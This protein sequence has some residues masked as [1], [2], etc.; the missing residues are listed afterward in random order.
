MSSTR[1]FL[2][3]FILFILLTL[4]ITVPAHAFDGRGGD[5]L[6]IQADQV[7]NDD[8]YVGANEFTLNGTVNGD[9]YVGAQ[10]VTINGTINGNLLAGAQS[11]IVNGTVTGDVLAAGSVLYLGEKARVGGDVLGAAYSLESRKGAQVGRDLVYAGGQIKLAG[12]V[13]RDVSA[14]TGAMEID[15]T[16]GGNVKA[17]V[18][19]A[20]QT[21]AG[22]PPTMFMQQTT[23]AV[24]Q[25]D[26]GLTIDPDAKI[27][28]NLNYTQNKKL[29]FPEGVIAG[30][31]TRAQ[32]P[33]N[34]AKPA[35]EETAGAKVVKW[36]FNTLR[37]LVTIIL[38][39]L[40]L[41]WLL[42]VFMNSLSGNLQNKPWPS[43]GWGLVTYAGFFFALLLIIF[44][45]ILGGVVFGLLTLGG[46]S[47]TI[48]GL[49]ILSLLGLILGFVLVVSF[50][51][52]IVFGMALGRWILQK[53]D[54]PLA[55]HRYWP[56][57][58]GVAITV[59]VVAVLS[60]PLLPGFLGWLLNLLIVLF[61]L[62]ALWLWGRQALSKKP[63]GA[64]S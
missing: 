4:T 13:T 36:S 64:A 11:V 28:G 12:D 50:L 23:V 16:V 54:S 20:D 43:L 41:L 42:P 10:T 27:S 3:I 8:L 39:G 37:S 57:V 2:S 45:T 33:S 35:V 55:D 56:M 62:G 61:G 26:P 21:Q 29:A 38:L 47:W 51:A 25:V 59:I 5:K 49:G 48:A 34:Q 17:E 31:V 14:A 19:E 22:P 53:A 1:K 30:K 24:P 46:L 7:I 15:G 32:Q 52:K 44:L 58:I 6:V 63:A 40:L 60:F 18:G 9:V